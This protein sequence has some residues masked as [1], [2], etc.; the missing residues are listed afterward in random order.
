MTNEKHL[1]DIQEIRSIMERSTRFMS[2][3]GLSGIMAGIYA[4]IGAY[5]AQRH[6]NEAIEQWNI[7]PYFFDM[8]E[9]YIYYL[10]DAG[11]ILLFSIGTGIFLTARRAKTNGQKMWNSTAR[12]MLFHVGLP[13]VVGAIVC[14][15]MLYHREESMIAPVMLIFY[16]LGLVNGSHFTLSDIKY[17]G[18]I[19]IILGLL[20]AFFVHNGIFFWALGFGLMHVVYGIYMYIKYEHKK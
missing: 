9:Y 5:F 16:G 19:E 14:V 8:W 20:S 1:Q 13:L 6:F 15:A 10:I 7:I 12:R 2:L 17:L 11:L 18:Y 4:L 3:S